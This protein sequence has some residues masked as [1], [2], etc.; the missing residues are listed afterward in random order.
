M[1]T[2]DNLA[3]KKRCRRRRLSWM[4]A[5]FLGAVVLF[6]SVALR[7]MV[8]MPGVSYRGELPAADTRLQA[9]E[10]ELRT[11]VAALAVEI[12][13]RNVGN[14]PKQLAQA[15]DYIEARFAESGYKVGRQLHS[16]PGCECY[17]L[18]VQRLGTVRPEE[19]VIVGAHYDSALGTPGANDNASGVA[20]TLAL[21][22]M[23]STCAT[24]RTIR[25]AAFVNEE[26]PYFHTQKGSCVYARRCRERGEKVVAMLSLETIGYY[27]D[28]PGSQHYPFPFGMLY[29]SEGNFIA[30]IGNTASRGVVCRAV[31]TFR[32]HEPL[33]S[34]GAAVP[35]WI[36]GTGFSDHQSFWREGYPALM[37]TDTAMFRYPHYHEPEDTIDKIDFDR[38][39]RVVRG[40]EKVVAELAGAD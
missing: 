14:R 8:V 27:N 24:E 36:R 26:P 21:A 9:L 16:V 29:P 25:F 23:F 22:R 40:L 39:A 3:L 15:A 10:S 4:A 5:G 30:F 33:P 37:V 35:E 7:T 2:A 1:D 34:E 6:V 17:N 20:A 28:A 12:G 11:T 38:M 13:E 19:I 18:D 31:E 32:R